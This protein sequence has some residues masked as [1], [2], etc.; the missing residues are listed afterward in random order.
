MISGARAGAAVSYY[1]FT[2]SQIKQNNYL[3]TPATNATI[4]RSLVSE[5][6]HTRKD[7]GDPMFIGR[8]NYFIVTHGT[9]GLDDG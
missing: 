8:L 3:D 4:L 1:K 9:T 7:H 5:M 6:T 2:V